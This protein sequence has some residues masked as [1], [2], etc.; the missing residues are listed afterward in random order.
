MQVTEVVGQV[1]YRLKLLPGMEQ[2]HDVF[3]C[4]LLR[5]YHGDPSRPPPVVTLAGEEEYEV[6]KVL[7][8]RLVGKKN[9]RF[10]V[11]WADPTQDSEWCDERDLHCP[12]L[13][14]EYWTYV[15]KL[16]LAKKVK[17]RK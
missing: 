15:G 2:L 3:H 14:R 12:E 8:H 11:Q 9:M 13:L 17:K 7:D 6:K 1:A 5:P 10:L 16:D 4:S